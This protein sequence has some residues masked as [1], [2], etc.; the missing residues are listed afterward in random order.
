MMFLPAELIKKKRRGEAL[1]L[2]EIHF[3]ISGYT[4]GEI[5]DYQM[6]AWLMAVCFQG[7]SPQETAHLTL[8]MKNSGR[9]FNFSHLERPRIDKHST[10]GVGDKTSIIL[11]PLVAACGLCVPMISGRGLGHTGGTLDKLASIPGF[12]IDLSLEEFEKNLKNYGFSAMGQ[13]KEICPADK[14]LYAL[15]DV[16]GTVDSLP[17]ICASIMSKK[18]AEDLSGLVLDVKFGSGA[19]MKTLPQARELAQRLKAL[20]ELNGVQVS[21]LLTRMDQ[22]LGRFVGNALEIKECV[23]ILKGETCIHGE[24]DFYADTRELTLLLAA[25]MLWLGKLATSIEDGLAQARNCLAS[26]SAYEKFLELC[27]FQGP[28]DPNKLPLTKQCHT[29]LATTSGFVETMDCEKIGLAGVLLGAGR[30]TAEDK[31]NPSAGLEVLVK[32]GDR[33]EHKQPVFNIYYADSRKL[34]DALGELN[35]AVTFSHSPARTQP[36]VAEVI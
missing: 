7:M 10:G 17:L 5:P 22:P 28:S 4:K 32:I 13:T 19:F 11:L 2:D 33:V 27:R 16:T 8:E 21:A 15:R 3:L 1:S 14:K 26:G 6:S 30:K 12:R 35:S 23:E 31:I 29:F 36:L 25:H 20:G 9:V 24:H 34:E 18:L